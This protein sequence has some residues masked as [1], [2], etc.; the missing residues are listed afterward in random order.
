VFVI[1]V[2]QA[3]RLHSAA[4]AAAPQCDPGAV[5]LTVGHAPPHAG[6]ISTRFP[7]VATFN[8]V[9]PGVP[10]DFEADGSN[11]VEDGTLRR[12]RSRPP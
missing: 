3:G 1:L 4:G 5:I 6:R 10:A 2:V 7:G 12:T 11:N 9:G 8:I